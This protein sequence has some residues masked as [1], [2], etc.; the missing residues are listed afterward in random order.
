M[1]DRAKGDVCKPKARAAGGVLGGCKVYLQDEADD[2]LRA[3]EQM[4]VGK[5]RRIYELEQKLADVY[6]Q[7]DIYRQLECERGF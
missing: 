2:Y 6:R 7:L 1:D 4:I 5:Q 3:L